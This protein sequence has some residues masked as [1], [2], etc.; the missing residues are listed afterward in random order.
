MSRRG[1][2][3]DEA[4]ADAIPVGLDPI[5]ARAADREQVGEEEPEPAV[6]F[7][8]PD[9]GRFDQ[10]LRMPPRPVRSMPPIS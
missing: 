5:H 9:I 10:V 8:K 6:D 3:L 4:I 1:A 7:N 2:G